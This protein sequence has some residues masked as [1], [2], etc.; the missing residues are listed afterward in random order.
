VLKA[1]GVK[2][3]G[4]KVLVVAHSKYLVSLTLLRINGQSYPLG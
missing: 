4:A 3:R 1:R 2:A